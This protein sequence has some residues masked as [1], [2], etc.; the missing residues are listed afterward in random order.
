MCSHYEAP[1]I[2]Q[3]QSVFGTSPEVPYQGELWP[4][5]IGPFIRMTSINGASSALKADSGSFGLLPHWAKDKTFA[6]NTFNARSEMVSEKPS[7]RNAWKKRQ[8]CLIPALAIYEPDWRSGKA[9]ATRIVHRTESL[10]LIAGIW[11]VWESESSEQVQ[12]YSMLT[13][14]AESHPVM[15]HYHRPEKEKRM[16]AVLSGEQSLEWLNASPEQAER[17]VE[18]IKSTHVDLVPA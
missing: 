15:R 16:V 17:I 6:R 1:S 3:L 13:I 9:I 12:S 5:S 8:Y 18:E 7:F 2:A 11:E 4:G 10:L 14:D